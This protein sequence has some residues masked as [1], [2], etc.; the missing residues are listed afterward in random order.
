MQ[1][2]IKTEK[3]PIKLWLKD[4][5]QG[6]ME[7]ARNIANLPFVHSHIAIMPDAHQGYGM[8]IGGVM[9]TEGVV[10]PNAVGVDIGCGMCALQTS[11]Q[12]LD[13]AALRAI[14]TRIRKTIP[15][16]F[17]HRKKAQDHRLMPRPENGVSI[18]DL[19]VVSREYTNGLKQLGTLGGGNHFIEIQQGSD[20][21]IWI[22]IHSGSR[23]LGYTVARFYNK[24]AAKMGSRFSSK[25]PKKWQLDFLP[26]DSAEGRA[27]LQEM[28]FC[29][30][31]AYAN[32]KLMMERVKEAL[33]EVAT[34][35]QFGEFINIAHNYAALETHFHKELLVHRK[36]ATSAKEGEVG[37][38][39][40]SQGTPSYL[41]R[42]KGNIESFTSCSH[43]AGRKMGR[44]QARRSLDL[45]QE[46]KRLE[47]QGIL[48]AV[49]SRRDLDEAAGA[50]KDIDQVIENQLDLVEVLVTLKPLAVIKG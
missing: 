28:A 23:N 25:I 39:P 42:G 26:I 34:A 18:E 50:Y 37:I 43:G 49:R 27:Y 45:H 13:G 48:H 14:L 44:K 24:L 40:G 36:G 38:I 17:K 9:A 8:P 22:M 10:I 20:G 21:H 12:S 29:V 16:G 11:L 15:L 47:D 35:V 46:Q 41:V 33:Q 3:V 30:D 2:I 7:Q 1:R 5:D 6:A 4:I 19:Q 32:R 31:F